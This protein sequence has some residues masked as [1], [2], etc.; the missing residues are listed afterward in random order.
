MFLRAYH[1][2]YSLS[3]VEASCCRVRN[4]LELSSG[5]DNADKHDKDQFMLFAS[6]MNLIACF[7]IIYT[8]IDSQFKVQEGLYLIHGTSRHACR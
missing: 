1:P 5:E 2:F 8:H 7:V 4:C 6:S 3:T